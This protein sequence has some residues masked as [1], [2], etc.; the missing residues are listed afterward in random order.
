[1]IDDTKSFIARNIDEFRSSGG[2]ISSFA[3]AP[4]LLL[5]TVGAR[6][7]QPRTNPLMYLDD[8]SNAERVFVFASAAGSDNDPAWLH[9]LLAH[10][11]EVVVEI[12]ERV[13]GAWA[14][15]LDEPVR[16]EV[17]RRQA[18]L[19]PAFD[20]YQQKTERTIPVVSLTLLDDDRAA[21]SRPSA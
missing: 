8:E 6:S 3:D 11:E 13:R 5:N 4:M 1:M 10:P 21:E 7:G 9:N 19:R 15:V 17:F 20:R 14:E 18:N 12:G 16:S 2:R